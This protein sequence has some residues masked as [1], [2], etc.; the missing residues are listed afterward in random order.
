LVKDAS[1]RL[2]RSVS[3]AVGE[4]QP[5]MARLPASIEAWR[6]LGQSATEIG[7]EQRDDSR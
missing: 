3:V 6:Y 7:R 5:E 1:L 4:M 2:A